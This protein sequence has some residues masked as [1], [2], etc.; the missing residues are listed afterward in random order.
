MRK[1]IDKINFRRANISDAETYFNWVNDKLVR[2]Q[3][4]LSNP[5]LWEEHFTWFSEKLKDNSF[6]FYIF[7][8]SEGQNLGQVRIQL[9]GNLKA[10]IGISIDSLFRGKGYGVFMLIMATDDF[11]KVNPYAEI[12][13]FIKYTNSV[14]KFIFE[15]ANFEYLDT[16]YYKNF[17]SY[18]YIK[19]CK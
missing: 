2:D 18:H 10:E 8:N 7:S 12:N 15:K 14:S 1:L 4:Y 17:K 16:I 6:F 11:F 9:I 19:K 3:S 5:I 13:A